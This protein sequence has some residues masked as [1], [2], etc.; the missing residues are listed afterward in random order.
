MG[1]LDIAAN[2]KAKK[3]SN[4]LLLARVLWGG[5][6][7]IFRMTPR[8]CW[9]V[10]NGILRLF[11]AKIG[12][13]VRIHASTNIYFPWNLAIGSDSSIGEWALV[14]SLGKI[15][16]GQRTTISQRVHLCAGT[17]DFTN[18]TM[19]LIRP[20]I[21]INDDVWVCADAFV[22]PDVKI[23]DGAV[24]GA[25]S[26]VVKDVPA[27]TVVAGN[28]AKHIKDRELLETSIS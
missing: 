14:Y 13:N 8:P 4:K 22:G 27:W 28:P 21:E 7:L 5:G 18:R 20:P 26:V 15:N 12:S 25:C 1:Q 17:H 6:G 3:Y 9:A 19:P 23:K 24:V 16:I 10:R 11:G 2:R